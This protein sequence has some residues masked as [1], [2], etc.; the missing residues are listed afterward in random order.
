[1]WR[2][3]WLRAHIQRVDGLKCCFLAKI[4]QISVIVNAIERTGVVD[5]QH[6]LQ[7]DELLPLPEQSRVRVIVLAPETEDIP[8]AA[9]AK[10]TSAS[11]AFDFLT[12]AAEDVYTTADG[13]P[14]DDKG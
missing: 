7:L 3:N 1:M 8:A 14:F 2:Q 9:W 5:D 12:D 11:P 10:A 13:R 6:Q 4:R